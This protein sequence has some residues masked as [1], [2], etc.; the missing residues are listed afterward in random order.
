M[1]DAKFACNPNARCC[2][3]AET[4]FGFVNPSGKL[5]YTYYKASYTHQVSMDDFGC[6]KPPGRGYRYLSPNSE[7]ILLPA[8]HG[9]SYTSF[10]MQ[11]ASTPQVLRNQPVTNSLELELTVENTGGRAG[12]ETVLAFFRPENRTNPGG[13]NLLPLQR[14]LCGLAKTGLLPPKGTET[15]HINITVDSFAMADDGGALVSMPGKYSIIL[16][17]GTQGAEEIHVPLTVVGERFVLEELPP[18]I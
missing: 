3:Y 4:L 11:A 14:R 6:A 5:P 7:H 1:N 15:L 17:T 8:F 16:S 12:A 13:S 10:K 2:M 9:L 18:G